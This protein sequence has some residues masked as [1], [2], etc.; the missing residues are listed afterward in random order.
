MRTNGSAVGGG[1]WR[2]SE[3]LGGQRNLTR[4]VTVAAPSCCTWPLH[5]AAKSVPTHAGRR[6]PDLGA[7]EP[8][9]RGG[10]TSLKKRAGVKWLMCPFFWRFRAGFGHAGRRAGVQVERPAGRTTWTPAPLPAHAG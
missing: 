5:L 6:A 9:R 1:H 4:V 7:T 2:R 10:F 3:A 8:E